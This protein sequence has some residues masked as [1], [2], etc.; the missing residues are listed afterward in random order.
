MQDLNDTQFAADGNVDGESAEKLRSEIYKCPNC[1]NFLYYDPESRKL[2]C[3]YCGG[4][5]ELEAVE[6]ASELSYHEGVEEGF[7]KWQ[8]VKSVKCR[9]CGAV[10]L[11]PAYEVVV[12]CP[13]CNASNV[14]ESEEIDGLRPNGILP[15]R[16]SKKEVPNIFC[17]W[18]RSKALAPGRL[19]KTADR[20]PCS[21][22]YVP[23]FTFDS[24]VNCDYKIRYGKYYTVTV[25]SGK[26]RRTETRTRWYTD[27]DSISNFFNDVQI[28]AS[29]SI[30]QKNLEKLGGFDTD[31]SVQY[32][33]Q[34]LSGYNAERYDKS[35]DGSWQEAKSVMQ[36]SL[37]AMIVSRYN[38][39]VVDYV[40][41]DCRFADNTYKYVLVPIWV[42]N[43]IYSNKNYACIINGRSGRMIGKY[44]KSGLKIGGIAIAV[45][46]AIA[47]IV[48]LY[49]KFIA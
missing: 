42:F 19:K 44:P 38:A 45:A 24:D 48:L 25:G 34:F 31:N 16:I 47:A 12:N 1:G 46:A 39:D 6:D 43:Y 13:F 23:V 36:N 3:D 9:S 41:M 35:L 30:T 27:I 49:F 40:D 7:E 29:K 5:K 22:V 14:V 33:S 21:G 32:H 4:V 11:L 37:R 15:F 26:N 10:T 20:Q 28:E 8:G 17:K 18:L 2:K